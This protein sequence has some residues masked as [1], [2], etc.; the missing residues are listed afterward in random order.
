MRHKKHF[1]ILL[2]SLS[3]CLPSIAQ[4]A[5]KVK[6]NKISSPVKFDGH[7]NESAWNEATK[8]DL[9]QYRPHYAVPPSQKSDVYVG[10]DDKY[11]WLAARLYMDD[12]S[13]LSVTTKSRDNLP[14]SSDNFGILIDGFNDKETALTFFTTPTGSRFDESLSGD[15]ST[16]GGVI[17]GVWKNN[18]ENTTWNTFWDVKTTHD[19]KGWYVE[20]RIPFSSL[21]FKP[22]EHDISTMGFIIRRTIASAAETDTWPLVDEKYGNVAFHK[23]SQ[24]KEVEIEGAKPSKPI[25]V[26]PYISGGNTR[27]YNMNETGT[28]YTR[29]NDWDF[30]IGGDLKYDIN[31]KLTLDVTVNPDFAQAEADDQQVNLTRYTINLAEKR[32][33]FQERSSLFDYV[34]DGSSNLFYSRNIGLNSEGQAV[35]ILGGARLTGRIGQWDIGVM[36]MQTAAKGNQGA[37]NFGVIRMRRPFINKWSY[38]GGMVNTRIGNHGSDNFAYGLDATWRMFGDEYV[39]GKVAQ[40]HNDGDESQFSLHNTFATLIWERRSETH[41]KYTFK[42]W[43]AGEQFNPMM[44]YLQRSKMQM[45]DGMI[46]YGF[47]FPRTSKW[48]QFTPSIEYTRYDRLTDNQLESATTTAMI[49]LV[50]RKRLQLS[51]SATY[52]QEGVSAPY[53]VSPKENV[54]VNAGRYHFWY[55]EFK[56]DLPKTLK[57]YWNS[58]FKYGGFYDGHT[59]NWTFAPRFNISQSLQLEASYQ[60]NYVKFTD[61]NQSTTLHNIGFKALYMFDTKWSVNLYTQYQSKLDNMSTN[62]RLHFNPKEGSDFYLVFNDDRYFKRFNNGPIKL[63]SYNSSTIMLKYTYTFIL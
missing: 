62:A 24:A 53:Y 10:Y 41:L 12:M 47:M 44:G 17:G 3:A 38:I 51:L 25:Y 40:T 7:V 32:S 18:W 43:Y 59:V 9:M 54:M 37:E 1:Y 58:S 8:V 55:S 56:I 13:K 20:M 19:D 14:E 39:T 26:T 31:S 42:Y 45:A 21:K 34:L 29:K 48:F 52:D 22:N 63:P 35:T 49:Q 36:D 50:S 15:A 33:F 6:I 4:N 27:S 60:L 16:G 61:R 5:G 23:S 11:L 57:W 2:L 28:A 30:N 46:Q